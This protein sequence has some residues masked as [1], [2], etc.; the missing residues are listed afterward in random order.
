M[1]HCNGAGTKTTKKMT[2]Y[3]SIQTGQTIVATS[4]CDSECVFS[5]KVI[6]RK[7]NFATLLIKGDKDPVKKK[8]MIDRDGFEYIKALGNYSMSPSFRAI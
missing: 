5:A 4:V 7:G 2:T 6:L 3:K 1:Y 8:V